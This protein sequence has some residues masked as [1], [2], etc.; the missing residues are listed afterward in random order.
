MARMLVHAV[1]R[2]YTFLHAWWCSCLPGS[3]LLTALVKVDVISVNHGGAAA[4]GV[5]LRQQNGEVGARERMED[6]QHY[7]RHWYYTIVCPILS[8]RW[9]TGRKCHPRRPLKGSK[10]NV[11]NTPPIWM[12][13]TNRSRWPAL[14]IVHSGRRFYVFMQSHRPPANE[15]QS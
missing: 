1:A 12:V 11:D 5:E 10:E 6:Q 9:K 13:K 4:Y 15:E 8:Q 3:H 7:S 2:A 14:H